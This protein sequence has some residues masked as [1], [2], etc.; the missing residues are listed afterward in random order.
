LN[1]GSAVGAVSIKV[2][3]RSLEFDDHHR[4]RCFRKLAQRAVRYADFGNSKLVFHF[5]GFWAACFDMISE[6]F[7]EQLIEE[8]RINGRFFVQGQVPSGLK[9]GPL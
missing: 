4:Y 8:L 2:G 3:K 9:I 6:T 1:S 7:A 5:I